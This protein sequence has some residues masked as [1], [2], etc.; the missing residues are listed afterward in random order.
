MKKK[1]LIFAHRGEAK[2]FFSQFQEKAMPFMDG[3]YESDEHYLL[4]TGEGPWKAGPKLGLVLGQLGEKVEEV[5]NLGIA[6]ALRAS[7]EVDQVYPIR[8]VY[9][10]QNQDMQFASHTL[11]HEGVDLITCH[12]RVLEEK[13]ANHLD[14][15]A[16]VVDR[17]LWALA[18]VCDNSG[19]SLSSYKLIS[20]KVGDKEICQRVKELSD[21]YSNQLLDF[22]MSQEWQRPGEEEGSSWEGFYFTTSLKNQREKLLQSLSV[23][24]GNL[25]EALEKLAPNELLTLEETPKRKAILLIE[26]MRSLLNPVQI[27]MQRSLEELGSELTRAGAQIKFPQDFERP[28]FHLSAHINKHEDLVAL[29]KAMEEFNYPRLVDLIEG[30]DLN[31]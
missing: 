8:T 23:K 10:E 29:I 26:K 25:E 17:E 15:F 1:L 11:G 30:K 19:H 6:G 12:T 18:Q 24:F 13:L 27:E 4:I 20:D 31:V 3:L 2:A 22:Y 16:P 28:Q 5:V 21:R 7:I 14:N 9:L